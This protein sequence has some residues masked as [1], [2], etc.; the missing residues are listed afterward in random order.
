MKK[1]KIKE[2]RKIDLE[3]ID[4]SSIKII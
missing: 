2:R 1:I 4:S 3:K